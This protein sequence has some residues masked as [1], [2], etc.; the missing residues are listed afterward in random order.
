MTVAAIAIKLAAHKLPMSAK[1]IGVKKLVVVKA[2]LGAPL[3]HSTNVKDF[4]NAVD[5]LQLA[6]VAGPVTM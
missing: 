5:Q 2:H 4:V 3:Y 6:M 1:V